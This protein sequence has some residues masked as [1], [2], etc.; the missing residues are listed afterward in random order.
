MLTCL[1]PRATRRLLK[2]S[3]VVLVTTQLGAC[4]ALTRQI[5]ESQSTSNIPQT[6]T[7]LTAI[8]LTQAPSVQASFYCQFAD[9]N[10]QTFVS[11]EGRKDVGFITWQ[12]TYFNMTPEERCREV[13]DRFNQF[14][15]NGSL[16]TL[17]AGVYNNLGVVC[18][19]T[20]GDGE[21]L[22]TVEYNEAAS[23]YEKAQRAYDQLM[24]IAQNA[25]TSGEGLTNSGLVV[26]T[27]DGFKQIHFQSFLRRLLDS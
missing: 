19:N 24:A 21:I 14:Y 8:D 7:N 17:K 11:L 4:G 10:W 23:Q 5:L 27:N 25:F 15:Q 13:A 3:L 26:E 2:T 12:T 20:C 6:P 9:N 1:V 22:F 16:Q 18:V